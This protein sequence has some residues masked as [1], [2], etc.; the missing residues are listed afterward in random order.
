MLAEEEC[1]SFPGAIWYPSPYQCIDGVCKIYCGDCKQDGV[2][3]LGDLLLIINY[4][5][6][7]G[8]APDPLCI[9][10]VSCDYL[11]DLGDVL[12]LVSYLYKGGQSPCEEC[13]FLKAGKEKFPNQEIQGVPRKLP[14]A[15]GDLKQIE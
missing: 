8:P 5:Y 7:S 2:I 11:V 1:M 10:D 15:P 12:Y 6:K 14:Q 9:G 3:D 4:L 13:C